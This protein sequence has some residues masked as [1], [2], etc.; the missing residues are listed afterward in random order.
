M[1]YLNKTG[2]KLHSKFVGQNR[3]CRIYSIGDVL[4]KVL[5]SSGNEMS[6]K[7][8]ENDRIEQYFRIV[9]PIFQIQFAAVVGIG[10]I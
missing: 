7:R 10:I 8:V 6:E 5:G 3:F 2:Y 4:I 1:M 9:K